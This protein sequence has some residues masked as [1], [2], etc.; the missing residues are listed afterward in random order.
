MYHLLCVTWNICGNVSTVYIRMYI[1]IVR[2][3]RNER[4]PNLQILF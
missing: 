1:T 4:I 3:D 2:L